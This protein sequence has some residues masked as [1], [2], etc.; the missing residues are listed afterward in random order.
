MYIQNL[1][2]KYTFYNIKTT[3]EQKDSQITLT[4]PQIQQLGPL[5][6]QK[7]GEITKNQT[8]TNY[9]IKGYVESQTEYGEQFKNEFTKA[10]TVT[11]E[12]TTQHNKQTPQ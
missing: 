12:Q 9:Q 10:T 7:I 5:M 4:T 6:D 3:I 1:N 2:E 11:Q 8:P